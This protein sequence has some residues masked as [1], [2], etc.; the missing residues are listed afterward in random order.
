MLC[1]A[2]SADK[3]RDLWL[4]TAARSVLGQEG[5]QSDLEAIE[6]SYDTIFGDLE[7][8]DLVDA[9]ARMETSRRNAFLGRVSSDGELVSRAVRRVRIGARTE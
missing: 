1:R 7:R 2:W 8:A 4:R 9:L 5:D 6:G 3:N